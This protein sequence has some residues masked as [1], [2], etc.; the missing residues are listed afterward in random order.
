MNRLQK[1]VVQQKLNDTLSDSSLMETEN[2]EVETTGENDNIHDTFWSTRLLEVARGEWNLK[3]WSQQEYRIDQP[4][5]L[6]MQS[7]KML[8]HFKTRQLKNY[9]S[10]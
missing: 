10:E 5:I 1:H 7:L 2:G 4:P 3:I 9:K 8:A 6:L